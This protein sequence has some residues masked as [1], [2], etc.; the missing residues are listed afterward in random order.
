MCRIVQY[1]QVCSSSVRHIAINRIGAHLSHYTYKWRCVSLLICPN[2]EQ[3]SA[4][5]TTCGPRS[6]GGGPASVT[7]RI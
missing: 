3:D 7:S 1:L 5:E 2:L 6:Y 4:P